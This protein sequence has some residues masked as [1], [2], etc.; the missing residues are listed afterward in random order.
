VYVGRDTSKQ[1]VVNLSDKRGRHRLRLVVDS[2]GVA[3]IEFLDESGR[4]THRIPDAAAP[5]GR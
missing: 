3:R 4:I 1:A 5:A 2:L